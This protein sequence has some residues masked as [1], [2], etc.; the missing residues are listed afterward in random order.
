MVKCVLE[1]GCLQVQSRIRAVSFLQ[2]QRRGLDGIKCILDGRYAVLVGRGMS[3]D[4]SEEL[5]PE[6][7]GKA[8]RDAL[9]FSSRLPD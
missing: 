8:F 6:E 7:A 9:L 2:Y 4:H 5:E 1:L 3:A